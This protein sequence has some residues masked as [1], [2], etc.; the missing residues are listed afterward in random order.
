MNIVS[1]RMQQVPFTAVEERMLCEAL[2]RESCTLCERGNE[3][4]DE[5]S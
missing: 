1:P 3:R 2:S 5:E 4:N